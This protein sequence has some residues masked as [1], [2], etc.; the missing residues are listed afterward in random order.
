VLKK[1]T[2]VVVQPE[3]LLSSKPFRDSGKNGKNAGISVN[4]KTAV[5]NLIPGV[6]G[7]VFEQFRENLNFTHTPRTS[8]GPTSSSANTSN[9]SFVAD[10]YEKAGSAED[11]GGVVKFKF[12]LNCSKTEK[13]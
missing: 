13:I 2:T 11:P 6:D 12:S 1:I 8:T 7:S 9:S 4:Q 5:E 10:A 3:M